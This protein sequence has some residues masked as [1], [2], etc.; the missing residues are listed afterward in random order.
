MPR[1]VLCNVS[2]FP[3]LKLQC[4]RHIFFPW[5]PSLVIYNALIMISGST[6]ASSLSENDFET[7][8]KCRHFVLLTQQSLFCGVLLE[9]EILIF[10]NSLVMM[11][12]NLPSLHVIK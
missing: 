3:E 9:Y 10:Y 6:S 11:K 4:K 5:Y 8:L 12:Y 2:I 1:I 7:I